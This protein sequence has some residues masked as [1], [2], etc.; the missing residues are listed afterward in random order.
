MQINKC[1]GYKQTP[2][3]VFQAEGINVKEGITTTAFSPVFYP[4]VISF[5]PPFYSHSGEFCGFDSRILE[6]GYSEQSNTMKPIKEIINNIYR[7]GSNLG[8]EA[9]IHWICSQL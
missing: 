5:T 4:W 9:P 1:W 2:C 3:L 7:R 6:Q 8:D